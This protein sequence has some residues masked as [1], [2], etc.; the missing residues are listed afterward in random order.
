MSDIIASFKTLHCCHVPDYHQVGWW[1]SQAKTTKVSS[2]GSR[3]DDQF[4]LGTNGDVSNEVVEPVFLDS[5]IKE[6]RTDGSGSSQ[7]YAARCAL[8]LKGSFGSRRYLTKRFDMRDPVSGKMREDFNDVFLPAAKLEVAATGATNPGSNGSG[9]VE[10]LGDKSIANAADRF[11]RIEDLNAWA[12]GKIP[13]GST[14]V[15]V[16]PKG[17]TLVLFDSVSLPHEVMETLQVRKKDV[18]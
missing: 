5:W 12:A 2:S 14:P 9:S 16:C 7:S 18:L 15:V 4:P 8:Y 13:V 6:P 10:I 1:R 17:G 11:L 3:G